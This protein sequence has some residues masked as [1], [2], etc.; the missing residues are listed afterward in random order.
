M[1]VTAVC[2]GETLDVTGYLQPAAGDWAAEGYEIGQG[3]VSSVAEGVLFLK[4]AYLDC[5]WLII[6]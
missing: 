2:A 1:L 4:V 3:L 5:A 6:W